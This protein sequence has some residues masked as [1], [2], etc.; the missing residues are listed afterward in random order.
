VG[1]FVTAYALLKDFLPTVGFAKVFREPPPNLSHAIPLV[2]VARFGGVDTAITVDRP[3]VQIDVYASTADAAEKLG[4]DIWTAMRTKLP[5]YVF[6]GAV[7][8]QVGTVMAPQLVPYSASGIFKVTARYEI[9]VHQ[10][11]GIS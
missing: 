5:H 10:Y 9:A 2:T 1:S 4:G 11:T 7:V 6:D 8:G 3:R